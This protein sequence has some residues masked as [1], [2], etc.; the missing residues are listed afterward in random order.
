MWL[1]IKR[2]TKGK[3]T[4]EEIRILEGYL[5][6]WPEYKGPYQRMRLK[7][8]RR[9]A[10]LRKAE[11]VASS[12][13]RHARD[14]FAVR[15]RGLAQVALVGLPNVGKSSLFRSLT[16][17]AAEI[18]DYPYTTLVPKVGMLNLGGFGFEIVDLPPISEGPLHTL[19]YA[20]HLRTA[21]LS[22]DLLCL[23]ID[24][25]EGHDEQLCL[26]T[27]RLGEVG[28]VPIFE[29]RGAGEPGDAHTPSAAPDT[30]RERR[31]GEAS[32]G[33]PEA[34]GGTARRQATKGTI[35]CG[36]KLDVAGEERLDALRKACPGGFV[37][38]R[39]RE[40]SER[41]V[42]GALSD[43]LGKI[44]VYAQAPH[45]GDEPWAY[46]LPQGATAI[47]L[48]KEIHADLAREARRARISGPSS[49]FPGQEVGLEHVLASGDTVEIL[50]R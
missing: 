28:V 20:S 33:G 37:F 9:I 40:D 8:E 5:A 44:V 45:S 4:G 22:A 7:L 25:L 3:K 14:P 30:G 36:T 24:L 43:L 38:G 50:V 29:T 49:R 21:I 46:A 13:R 17:A 31:S 10:N 12:S 27:T 18:A 32:A 6:D 42:A 15:K 47:D 11:R 48:A 1:K 26:L 41:T 19:H 2:E 23:V 34:S 16:G 39:P 35:I